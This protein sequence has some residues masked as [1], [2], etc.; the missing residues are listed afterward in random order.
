MK[1][2]EKNHPAMWSVGAGGHMLFPA[3]Y[4][5]WRISRRHSVKVS[6]KNGLEISA[7]YNG[8]SLVFK[9]QGL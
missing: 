4:P 8:Y 7:G 5:D 1:L 9:G 3:F 2:N 6:L